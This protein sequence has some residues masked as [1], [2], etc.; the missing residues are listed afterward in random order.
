MLRVDRLQVHDLPAL[1]FDVPEGECFA[2]EGPSGSGKTLLLRAIADLDPADGYVTLDGVERGE[3]KPQDWRRQV[4]YV[5]AEPAWWL[6]TGRAHFPGGLA[7]RMA[8]MMHAVDLDEAQL[9]QPVHQLSRGEQQRLALVRA[10]IDDPKV[11]LLD[12][13]TAALDTATAAQIEEL[14]KFQLLAGRR[15]VLVSHDP[16]QV[17]RL[18]HQRLIL[19]AKRRGGA[20]ARTLP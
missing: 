17:N 10:V 1:S 18:S 4:R 6:G 15:I 7:E 5:A 9:D 12:E 2:V 16:A 14:I 8:R 13:P 11:L 20:I 3:M 19:G